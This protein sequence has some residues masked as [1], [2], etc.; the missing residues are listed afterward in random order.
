MESMLYVQ[1]IFMSIIKL[2]SQIYFN[3]N[4][5]SSI[6]KFI[7]KIKGEDHMYIDPA[8]TSYIIQVIA[9]IVISLG[10]VVG[11]YWKKIRLFFRDKKI[12]RT[13]K[14]LREQ[15]EKKD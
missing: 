11:V 10:V 8:A 1:S 12:A 9:G 6:I 14:K 13:E 4:K 2:Y 15:S 7:E 3:K 5:F